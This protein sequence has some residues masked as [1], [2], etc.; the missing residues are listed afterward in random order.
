MYNEQLEKLI[1]MALMDGELTDKEKQ[2][3]FKKA[4]SLSVDLDEFEMVLDARLYEKQKTQKPQASVI[5]PNNTKHGDYTK[6]PSCNAP[7][8]S[9]NTKC[10]DCGHE[11]RNI[12]SSSSIRELFEEMNKIQAKKAEESTSIKSMFVDTLSGDKTTARKRELLK[13]FPIPNTKEDILEF[14]ALAIPNCKKPS[15]WK[16]NASWESLERYE[17]APVWQSKCEQ[18]IIKARFSMKEDKNTME[19]IEHYANK[20]GIK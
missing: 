6:C 2:I 9:F 11:F 20:L 13:N 19:E 10:L 3:L 5:E 16:R 15:F 12:K 17:M 14:L 4:E 1:E 18:I 7:I 8:E